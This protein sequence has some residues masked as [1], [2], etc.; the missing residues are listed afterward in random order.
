MEASVSV[1]ANEC[2]CEC[3]CTLR[4]KVL[5]S[6]CSRRELVDFRYK[7]VGVVVVVVDTYLRNQTTTKIVEMNRTNNWTRAK[8]NVSSQRSI[9]V[10]VANKTNKQTSTEFEKLLASVFS[11]FS[12]F[13]L[14]I[15]PEFVLPLPL[16]NNYYICF[17]HF[18]ILMNSKKT[19]YTRFAF[20]SAC[21]Q[22]TLIWLW[23]MKGKK[24]RRTVCEYSVSLG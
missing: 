11:S 13:F 16:A 4:L 1:N 21:R 9:V 22:K 10:S 14:S 15:L 19:R 7:V 18:F 8:V 12:S 6:P 3:V 24:K 23:I 2:E 17:A 5:S 20:L